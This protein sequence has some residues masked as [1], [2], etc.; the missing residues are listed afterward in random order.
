MLLPMYAVSGAARRVALVMFATL[1]LALS[2]CS[3][4]AMATRG[5]PPAPSPPVGDAAAS[6]AP[7][8]AGPTVD[9]G[10]FDA[11]TLAGTPTVLWFWAPF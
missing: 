2:A 5:S 1:V 11:A 7:A 8:F 3:S 9:G 4:G 10:R 6:T